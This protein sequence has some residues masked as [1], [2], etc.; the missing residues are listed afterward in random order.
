MSS[1][2]HQAVHSSEKRI[3]QDHVRRFRPALTSLAFN[4]P[5]LRL[6]SLRQGIC[7]FVLLL[8]GIGVDTG[9]F[10]Q[11]QAKSRERE[12][13]R[14][15]QQS[16]QALQGE[17][18]DA[19]REK[20]ELAEKLKAA[21]VSSAKLKRDNAKLKKKTEELDAAQRELD[22]ARRE[23]DELKA[24]LADLE[25]KFAE[26]MRN[27][28]KSADDLKRSLEEERSGARNM[29]VALEAER[30]LAQAAT[31]KEAKRANFCEATNLK[32]Y[33]VTLDLINR[34]QTKRGTWQQFLSSE[35]FTQIKSVE[36]ENLL[37]DMRDKA[38]ANK[39]E[40]K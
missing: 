21:E 7:L 12:A 17:K 20:A 37:Q 38:D 9:A 36:V 28:Q 33:G 26:G 2:E 6:V 10:A 1:S 19:L 34:Y 22:A 35:P 14:R 11:D 27:W 25:Q 18:A 15:A 39:V 29:R 30:N 31:I 4:I 23:R 16:L 24:K 32:L 13:L 3:G 8:V 5:T 40:P